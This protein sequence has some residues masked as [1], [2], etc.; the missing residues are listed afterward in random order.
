MEVDQRKRNLYGIRI[1]SQIQK[2]EPIFQDGLNNL[3]LK[4]KYEVLF[5]KS[6]HATTNVAIESSQALYGYDPDDFKKK[7][8]LAIKKVDKRSLAA[9][10]YHQNEVN[11]LLHYKRIKG[12]NYI[13]TYYIE[14]KQMLED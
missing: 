14:E 13:P 6:I 2:A 7:L 3:L 9:E 12:S 5:L 4:A 11:F 8:D 10:N 1:L